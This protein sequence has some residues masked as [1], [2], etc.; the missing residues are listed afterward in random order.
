MDGA[1]PC[2]PAFACNV[3]NYEQTV[4]CLWMPWSSKSQLL[5]F[6]PGQNIILQ[7]DAWQTDPSS[8]RAKDGQRVQEDSALQTVLSQCCQ[9]GESSSS[10]AKLSGKFTSHHTKITCRL[11]EWLMVMQETNGILLACRK[12]L[13][14]LD[15]QDW[16]RI[17]Q[18]LQ[19]FLN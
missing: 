11:P 5:L 2:L 12:E 16:G 14:T 6:R 19:W 15:Q 3:S 4:F 17:L 7:A 1:K 13:L 10:L 9:S 18:S 8:P